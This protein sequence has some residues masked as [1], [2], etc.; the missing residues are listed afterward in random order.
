MS[1][2]MTYM[3]L[4]KVEMIQ[5]DGGGGKVELDIFDFLEQFAW[6][7]PV[8]RQSE[9]GA[10]ACDRLTQVFDEA[11]QHKRKYVAAMTADFAIL[12]P[13]ATMQG[14]QLQFGVNNRPIMRLTRCFTFATT[15][16]PED[17]DKDAEKGAAP[18]VETNGT[19]DQPTQ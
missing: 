12:L 6:G 7:D 18:K 13:V 16:K 17:F 2:A 10:A 8:F 14:K 5:K 19:T 9:T 3:Q 1:T 15:K 4:P 11:K